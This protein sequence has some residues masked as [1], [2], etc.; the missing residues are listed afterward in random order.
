MLLEFMSEREAAGRPVWSGSLELAAHAP[1]PGVVDRVRGE[2]WHG[3]DARRSVAVRAAV[4]LASGPHRASID[5]VIRL[6]A[7]RE[8][9]PALKAMLTQA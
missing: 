2:L 8:R 1:C 9:R 3:D 4:V 5:D 6:R 7:Q